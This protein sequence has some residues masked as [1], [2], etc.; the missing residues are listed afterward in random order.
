[1]D[2]EKYAEGERVAREALAIARRVLPEG[3]ENLL[4][5][6]VFLGLALVG[7]EN[8]AEAEPLLRECLEG[9]EATMP[10]GRWEIAQARSALGAALAV[11]G[12]F[13]EAEPLLLEAARSLRGNA[14]APGIRVE[15]SVERVVDLYRRWEAAEPTESR[16]DELRRWQ[17]EL[18]QVAGR[19]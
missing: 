12:R 13:E 15:N 5:T 7:Q 4:A 17:G 3:N 14:S 1:V 10:E 8:G 9:R 6:L 2:Q 16:R 19:T 11:Q 18:S